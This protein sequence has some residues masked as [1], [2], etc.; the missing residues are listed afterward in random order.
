MRIRTMAETFRPTFAPCP[1]RARFADLHLKLKSCRRASTSYASSVV[2]NFDYRRVLL[3]LS[4]PPLLF[5]YFP[6][7]FF[8]SSPKPYIFCAIHVA[9]ASRVNMHELACSQD[10]FQS[11][12][13]ADRFIH[14]CGR[15]RM[16]LRCDVRFTLEGTLSQGEREC[17]GVVFI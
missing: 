16:C 2:F 9:R 1:C 5:I 4:P 6:F 3:P 15:R 13:P 7:L 12:N 11:R 17:F 8:F 10:E 14:R